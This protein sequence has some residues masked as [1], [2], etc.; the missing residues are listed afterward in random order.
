MTKEEPIYLLIAEDEHMLRNG[1]A[2]L[3][4][5]AQGITLLPTAKN[6]LQAVEIA[7][8]HTVDILLS[9]IRMPGLSGMEVAQFV[10]DRYPGA[11]IIFLSGYEEFDYAKKAISLHANNYILK[12]AMPQDVLRAV[13]AAKDK[14]LQRRR[15]EDA[16]RQM[17]ME[18]QNLS[19]VASVTQKPTDEPGIPTEEDITQVVSYIRKHYQEPLNLAALAEEFHFNPVYLSRLIKKKSGHT[20]TELLTSVRMY[21]AARLFA[22]LI[23]YV[24]FSLP[25]GFFLT[26]SYMDSVPKE[27][28]EAAVIDGCG[29]YRTLLIIVLPM[30]KASIATVSIMTYLNNWNEFVMAM[31]FLSSPDWKTLPFAVLEFTGQYSSDYAIQFA[32]MTLSALPAIIIYILLNKNITK[33]VAMG[34]VKG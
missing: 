33:G 29:V 8:E 21:H 10:R 9:D 31:T 22:L 30:M 32:V 23:P 19:K 1:L 12:P 15:E 34:A 25:Q 5:A 27:L 26:S 11:E 17:E 20:F 13:G 16:K 4:W 24:A 2:S 28:E 18:L 7:T 6:G 3:G 14:I